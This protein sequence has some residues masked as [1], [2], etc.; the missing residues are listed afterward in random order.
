MERATETM[1]TV[2]LPLPLRPRNLSQEPYSSIRLGE[3]FRN[4]S[5]QPGQVFDLTNNYILS[6]TY[7]QVEVI[8]F[9]RN[10]L[11][12]KPTESGTDI[13][14]RNL[15]EES[16]KRFWVDHNLEDYQEIPQEEYLSLLDSQYWSP[17]T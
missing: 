8:G 17:N 4:Q 10:M 7:F 6:N 5:Y 3:D 12:V 13:F 15:L 11:L 16:K 2:Y 1:T 9:Y 14:G